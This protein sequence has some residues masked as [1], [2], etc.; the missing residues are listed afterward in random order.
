MTATPLSLK[1]LRRPIALGVLLLLGS[2][3]SA[4]GPSRPPPG[5]AYASSDAR[6]TFLVR[7]ALEDDEVLA[8]F[9]IGVQVRQGFVTLLGR[10]PKAELIARAE[11]T[12]QGVPDLRGVRCDL[13]VGPPTDRQPPP[14]AAVAPATPPTAPPAAVVLLAPVE[15]SPEEP[16]PAVMLSARE[17]EPAAVE[18]PRA[19]SDATLLQ[20]VERLR[21][22]EPR[23]LGVR[24]EVRQG[25]VF[26]RGEVARAADGMDLARMV[27]RLPGV[28]D[29]VVETR[30]A[31][32]L[33]G[34]T[35]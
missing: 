5:P 3:A 6:L 17:R 9:N 11:A 12:A 29:V 21:W 32:Q 30:E 31:A 24:A 10:V 1:S 22:S 19:A 7:R 26:L 8:P 18:P 15:D 35:P 13:L 16:R 25:A 28:A 20:A 23:F 27:S 34:R 33:P 14:P 2:A 4:E